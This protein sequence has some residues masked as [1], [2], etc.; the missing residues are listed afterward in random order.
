[1][2][3]EVKSSYTFKIHKK[4]NKLKEQACL[5]SGYRFKFIIK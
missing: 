3:I 1:M 4:I 2:I 5:N